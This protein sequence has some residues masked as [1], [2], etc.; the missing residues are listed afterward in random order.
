MVLASQAAWP[1]MPFPGVPCLSWGN[2][3]SA[4]CQTLAP[5]FDPPAGFAVGKAEYMDMDMF[6]SPPMTAG[7]LRI[8]PSHHPLL[9][10]AVGANTGSSC[11]QKTE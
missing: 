11:G 2:C 10:M 5:S 3:P 6:H 4:C 8:K 7:P 1:P 9:Y